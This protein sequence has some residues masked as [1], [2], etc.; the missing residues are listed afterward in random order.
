MAPAAPTS[1]A[2]TGLSP[3]NVLG[4][5]LKTL[6]TGELSGMELSDKVKIA[7]AILEPILENARVE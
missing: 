2:Q 5:L 1:L 6:Y 3:D 4:L 7:Y